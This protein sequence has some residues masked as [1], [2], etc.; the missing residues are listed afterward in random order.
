MQVKLTKNELR[1]QQ[2]KLNQLEKYL[3][4]LQLKKAMLQTEVNSAHAEIEKLTQ[5]Y[6]EQKKFC[7]SFQSLL[8]DPEA[9]TLYEGTQVKEVEKR[10]EN[11]A[12]ADIPHFEKIHFKP[13]EYSLFDSPLW[14]DSGME[15]L[16]ELVSAK[17]QITVVEEKKTILE[18]ELRE[19][20]IRVNLFEKILIPR[21]KGDIKKIKVFLG[22]QELASVSQAKVA[23]KKI[24]KRREVTAA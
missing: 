22:D 20:S 4:T 21:T 15:K 7:E 9:I 10:Y 19:V 23:K 14:I 13:T 8:T 1:D 16:K 5:A 18:K 24:L 2:Y 3:P 17:A 12:G 11:I 6:M